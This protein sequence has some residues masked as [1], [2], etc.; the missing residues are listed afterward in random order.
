MLGGFSADARWP[1]RTS[2]DT[3]DDADDSLLTATARRSVVSSARYT[4]PMPPEPRRCCMRKRPTMAPV[5]SCCRAAPLGLDAGSGMRKSV[6]KCDK[7]LTA[8]ARKP[9]VFMPK[10]PAI[11]A[12]PAV[13]DMGF[14]R[15]SDMKILKITLALCVLTGLGAAEDRSPSKVV[16]VVG[17]SEVKVVPDR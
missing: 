4:S 1:S 15:R 6:L 11:F 16:R 14:S 13:L 2:R 9:R 12:L 7:Y 3:S 10:S 17:P 5:K 8:T